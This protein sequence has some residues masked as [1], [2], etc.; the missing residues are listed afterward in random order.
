M[1]SKTETVGVAD[2]GIGLS[3]EMKRQFPKM[4]FVL[5]KS[6]LKD[7]FYET[8]EKIGIREKEQKKWVMNQITSISDVKVIEYWKNLNKDM[9][10]MRAIG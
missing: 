3:E 6:H 8:A 7:H 1:T 9:I 4:Q 5:E 10:K 2:G